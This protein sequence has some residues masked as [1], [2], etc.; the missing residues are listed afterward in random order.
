MRQV[1]LS[2]GVLIHASAQAVWDYLTDWPRQAEWIPLTTVR[3]VDANTA[4]SGARISAWTGLG[5]L[6]FTDPMTITTW[7]PPHQLAVVHTGRIVRG[8]ANF[9][10]EPLA[11]AVR[12]TWTE[13]FGFPGGAAGALAWRL[14]RPLAQRGLD[15]TLR[16]LAKRWPSAGP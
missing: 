16:R 4:R 2:S 3:A 7:R 6:G 15:R 5:P 12:L 10:I 13:H 14:A 1:E 9:T 11:G 8:D